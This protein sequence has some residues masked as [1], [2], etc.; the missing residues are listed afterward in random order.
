MSFVL[1]DLSVYF[2]QMT[3]HVLADHELAVAN[4]EHDAR[5][6]V[7]IEVSCLLISTF[8]DCEAP[9]GGAWW[10]RKRIGTSWMSNT[11]PPS[12]KENYVKD[13]AILR[14]LDFE[15]AGIGAQVQLGGYYN[16]L[17]QKKKKK[18]KQEMIEGDN[19]L[20]AH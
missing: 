8:G 18:K 12:D 11:R 15:S 6:P 3:V 9:D 10:P 1:V 19:Q 2:C 7:F 5:V 4:H 13:T 17:K 14:S 20:Q 16:L